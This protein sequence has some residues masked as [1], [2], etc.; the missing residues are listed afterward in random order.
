[1]AGPDKRPPRKR[2]GYHPNVQFT[3]FSHCLAEGSPNTNSSRTA[4]HT[5][6]LAMSPKQEEERIVV[7]GMKARYAAGRAAC[8]AV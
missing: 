6:S 3:C 4:C 1:M 7:Y 8:T 5:P 2:M